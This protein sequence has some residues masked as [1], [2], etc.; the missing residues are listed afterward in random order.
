[1]RPHCV[2]VLGSRNNVPR[3][4]V[5]WETENWRSKPGVLW[6]ILGL[7][8]RLRQAG[9][10]TNHD[11]YCGGATK[12]DRAQGCAGLACGDPRGGKL[13]R[14]PRALNTLRSALLVSA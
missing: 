8:G 4:G 3:A 11:M 6:R 1:M 2:E 7:R 12:L 5:R 9:K 14:E 10:E 13:I